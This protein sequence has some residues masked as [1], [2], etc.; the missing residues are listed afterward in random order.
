[1]LK[2]IIATAALVAASSALAGAAT[3][4]VD[5][6]D[7]LSQTNNNYSRTNTST[8]TYNLAGYSGSIT[9]DAVTNALGSKTGSCIVYYGFG[10]G[11][12]STSYSIF[13]TF[14]YGDADPETLTIGM[15]NR[16]AFYGTWAAIFV[17]VSALT[18]DASL[19]ESFTYSYTEGDGL[20]ITAWAIVDGTAQSI[21][22]NGT[23][24]TFSVSDL[25][26]DTDDAIVL[27]VSDGSDSSGGTEVKT[28]IS[29]VAN[30]TVIPEPSAFGLL[31]GVGALALVAARRRRRR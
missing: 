11:G 21:T 27:L 10:N 23:S 28:T 30:V 29:L 19:L 15:V 18:S 31:A 24:G 4:T 3:T 5:I 20:T 8:T 12:D 13:S 2:S 1:M 16:P 17:T 25:N 22:L 7:L 14:E 26:L 9:A 6:I